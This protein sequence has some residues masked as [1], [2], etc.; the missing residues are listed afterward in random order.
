[1]NKCSKPLFGR[2]FTAISFSVY[3]GLLAPHV[4]SAYQWP[5]PTEQTEQGFLS[6]RTNTQSPLP[7]L[8]LW[9]G[10]KEEKLVQP[11]HQ[12]ETIYL[13]QS[14]E[15]NILGPLPRN[16]EH[17][18]IVQH[19]ELLIRYSS[20]QLPLRLQNS[21]QLG[22]QDTLFHSAPNLDPGQDDAEDEDSQSAVPTN[23]DVPKLYIEVFDT[24]SQTVI[25]P[26]LILPSGN[27]GSQKGQPYLES[28][29]LS[30][31]GNETAKKSEEKAETSANIS[32]PI[33]RPLRRSERLISGIYNLSFRFPQKQ[34]PPLKLYVDIDEKRIYSEVFDQVYG[35]NSRL[36]I[37]DRD[38][39]DIYVQAR[40]FL[41]TL[42]F[43]DKVN[44]T[45]RIQVMEEYIDGLQNRTEYRLQIR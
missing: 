15:M 41:G 43:Q 33:N 37:N 1:M 45:I 40:F 6:G 39:Q 19:E 9:F 22:K 10:V 13:E 17:T 21:Y 36:M 5:L 31:I 26:R 4:I 12:G 18:M 23:E 42:N 11:Y 34:G 32:G 44:S 16:I 27:T 38:L 14:A 7:N 30:D 29:L 2:C 20:K 35:I 25:N 3:F 24:Q 28:L 8:G